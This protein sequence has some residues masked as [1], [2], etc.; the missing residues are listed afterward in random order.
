MPY[1]GAYGVASLSRVVSGIIMVG[2]TLIECNEL[3]YTLEPQ[4][5]SERHG[6]YIGTRCA[7]A[8]RVVASCYGS[9]GGSGFGHVNQI[10][11]ALLAAASPYGSP[12]GVTSEV[13]NKIE[14]FLGTNQGLSP[15]ITPYQ[16][17][18]STADV[19][20]ADPGGSASIRQV[21]KMITESDG[22]GV[23]SSGTLTIVGKSFGITIGGNQPED[24]IAGGTVNGLYVPAPHMLTPLY[25][26][27]TMRKTDAHTVE[28]SI[29]GFFTFYHGEARKAPFALLHYDTG[30]RYQIGHPVGSFVNITVRY[31]SRDWP[32]Q[33]NALG[34]MQYVP[35]LGGTLSFVNSMQVNPHS[36][37]MGMTISIEFCH[38]NLVFNNSVRHRG[39]LAVHVLE[40]ASVVPPKSGYAI[41][42]HLAGAE[43]GLLTNAQQQELFNQYARMA[44]TALDIKHSLVSEGLD[45]AKNLLTFN[46]LGLL[47]NANNAAH[48][49]AKG[50]LSLAT[51]ARNIAFTRERHAYQN[52]AFSIQKQVELSNM[53]V[54]G[55]TIT[56]FGIP[57]AWPAELA[58]FAS[59]IAN[60]FFVHWVRLAASGI[61]KK[62][63]YKDQDAYAA[64]LK[65]MLKAVGIFDT[66][67]GSGNII[68]DVLRGTIFGATFDMISE[69]LEKMAEEIDFTKAAKRLAQQGAY[70]AALSGLVG[71]NLKDS[72]G[73]IPASFTTALIG[74]IFRVVG[75]EGISVDSRYDHLSSVYTVT[76]KAMFSDAMVYGMPAFFNQSLA[77]VLDI[78]HSFGDDNQLVMTRDGKLKTPVPC[79]QAW[80]PYPI[81]LGYN[82]TSEGFQPKA[83]GMLGDQALKENVDVAATLSEK[84]F[85]NLVAYQH[86]PEPLILKVADSVFGAAERSI[87]ADNGRAKIYENA[88]QKRNYIAKPLAGQTGVTFERL[89]NSPGSHYDMVMEA[90]DNQG[91]IDVSK[92]LPISPTASMIW[93][94]YRLD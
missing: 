89:R 6:I 32:G 52:M 88:W 2:Q 12:K 22:G 70:N 20:A 61:A 15:S 67:S 51:Q 1:S 93:F 8:G 66:D 41:T 4:Y 27:A 94:M 79:L 49:A 90:L 56:V 3:E 23:D 31:L 13:H 33:L 18:E 7:F 59:S 60:Y 91:G 36:D 75:L 21:Y 72:V 14:T 68:A 83:V 74:E 73:A 82:K 58:C 78:S 25:V 38:D 44:G 39:V 69:A 29:T 55:L 86:L 85:D 30:M 57:G 76:I 92:V 16:M 84:A 62:T 45:A 5:S 19:E 37:G 64:R 34:A 46:V 26:R 10:Y 53:V 77:N 87:T 80:I 17:P 71:S 47:N 40:D 81:S 43:R 24:S 50:A 54:R 28:L 11:N 42:S 65:M 48:T 63:L 35:K 9:P